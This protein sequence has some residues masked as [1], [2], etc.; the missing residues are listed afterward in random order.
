ML[1]DRLAPAVFT[2]NTLN[3]DNNGIGDGI[4][5]LREA[6][7]AANAAAGADTIDFAVTGTINLN[8]SLAAIAV[9]GP[10]TIDG[11]GPANSLCSI[12]LRRRPSG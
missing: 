3:D 10:L 1:D 9:T 8:Q 5:S 12:R 4:I 11:P 2:V 7:Q 6:I